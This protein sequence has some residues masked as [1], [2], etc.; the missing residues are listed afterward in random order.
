MADKPEV[1]GFCHSDQPRETIY[2]GQIEY[3]S[4]CVRCGATSTKSAREL[5]I[6]AKG[7][8]PGGFDSTPVGIVSKMLKDPYKFFT[9]RKQEPP[10]RDN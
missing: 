10:K 2:V 1:C 4:R 7:V 9:G 8:T 3:G 6:A 5:R